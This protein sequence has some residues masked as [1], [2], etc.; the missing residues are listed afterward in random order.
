MLKGDWRKRTA[1]HSC[2]SGGRGV[3]TPQRVWIEDET[4]K[5]V[6]SGPIPST[7]SIRRRR[8]IRGIRST[9]WPSPAK[10]FLNI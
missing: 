3:Y 7:P 5:I 8:P 6:E 10:R 4:G 1:F 9:N 2:R